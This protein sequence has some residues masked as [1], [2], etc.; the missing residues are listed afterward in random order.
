[1]VFSVIATFHVALVLGA[2]WGEFTQGGGTT[3][4]LPLSGRVVAAVSCLI[5]LLMAGAILG[6]VGRGPFRLR[7]S[8]SRS[9]LAW[10]A[11]AYAV[12]GVV[13][14]LITRSAGER[15][16]WAPLSI[17]LLGLV[18]FVMVTTH[19]RPPE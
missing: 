7:S 3:G 14:N 4:P 10:F 15:A 17:L 19:R 11:T 13:L 6:R 1:V 12:V 2:P 8:R 16:L 9:I 18:T 5:S